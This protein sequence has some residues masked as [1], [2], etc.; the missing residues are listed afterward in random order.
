[1]ME[2]KLFFLGFGAVRRGNVGGFR[3]FYAPD[4]FFG[5][6][7]VDADLVGF[8]G[9]DMADPNGAEAGFAPAAPD[10]DGLAG[11]GQEADA[12][13]ARAILAE[14]DG[15]GTLDKRMALGVGAL[16][17]D[18]ESFGKSRLLASFFPQVEDGL[19]EGQADA[20][21]AVGVRVEVGDA[22]F[23][24]LAAALVNEKNGVAQCEFGF[25]GDEGA[26]GIDEDR[27]S[28]FVEGA[29][30]SGKTVNHDW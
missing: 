29:A 8:G 11:G 7:T 13:E 28:V 2:K 5:L 25:Q 26:A 14:I 4:V 10:F 30:F 1:M 22:D 23:L 16:D 19:F 24:L 9:A 18:A 17:D 6:E 15:V 20:S 12:V 27:L 21:F 3:E